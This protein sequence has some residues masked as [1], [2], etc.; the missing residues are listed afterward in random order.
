MGVTQAQDQPITAQKAARRLERNPRRPRAGRS[1]EVH[2]HIAE[3]I[4][5]R[6]RLHEVRPA[7]K[8]PRRVPVRLRREQV[9]DEAVLAR[10]DLD[11]APVAHATEVRA[12]RTDR[13]P[14]RSVLVGGGQ[15]TGQWE[16]GTRCPTGIWR[17]HRLLQPRRHRQLL[18]GIVWVRRLHVGQIGAAAGHVV[19]AGRGVI[20]EH[21][22]R[23]GIGIPA[24]KEAALP[25]VPKALH[26]AHRVGLHHVG[27]DDEHAPKL[28]RR[29]VRQAHDRV[30]LAQIVLTAAEVAAGAELVLEGVRG[31][32]GGE[33]VLEVEAPGD[34]NARV[35]AQI[36]PLGEPPRAKEEA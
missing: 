33:L 1:V 2:H 29:T 10:I 23:E 3:Q 14:Q 8:D 31:G 17:H 15:A 24:G 36:Q 20:G 34:A 7:H 16:L 26:Q 21:G 30:R 9:A 13:S 22:A 19:T 27:L 12:H 18:P 6:H 25:V 28:Q 35:E 11:R 5:P 32:A 4:Q